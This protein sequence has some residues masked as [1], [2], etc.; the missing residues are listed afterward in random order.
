M[1]YEF[2]WDP[3]KASGN[4]A[5]HGVSFEDAMSVFLN[6]LALSRPDDGSGFGE[7]RWITIGQNIDMKVLLVVHTFVEISDAL[8]VIRIISARRPTKHEIRQYE[9]G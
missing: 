7:E 9:E 6:P 4:I 1:R 2:E 3:T 5:K 8:V